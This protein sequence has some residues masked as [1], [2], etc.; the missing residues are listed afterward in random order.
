MG[1]GPV[2]IRRIGLEGPDPDDTGPAIR[3]RSGCALR[4]ILPLLHLE[5][6]GKNPERSSFRKLR[7]KQEREIRRLQGTQVRLPLHFLLRTI[8]RL[9]IYFSLENASGEWNF[10]ILPLW[11]HQRLFGGLLFIYLLC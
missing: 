5:R 3:V 11:R 6:P 1:K 8:R 10:G 7:R 9:A 4:P 2:R